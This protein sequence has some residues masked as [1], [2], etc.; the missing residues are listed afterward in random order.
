MALKTKPAATDVAALLESVE[1]AQKRKDCYDIAAIMADIWRA[2]SGVGGFND[3]LRK[4]QIHEF[5][6]KRS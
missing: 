4:I 1:P 5:F 6:K 3:W 2:C